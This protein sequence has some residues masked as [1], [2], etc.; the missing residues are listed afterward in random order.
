MHLSKEEK[1]KDLVAISARG[2]IKISRY[3]PKRFSFI[4]LKF[5]LCFFRVRLGFAMC[6]FLLFLNGRFNHSNSSS[7]HYL[8][9]ALSC[10]YFG[11]FCAIG[12]IF[13][14]KQNVE[15]IGSNVGVW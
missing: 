10:V 15:G 9:F 8:T 1:A 11:F 3:D 2:E 6:L 14:S 7:S 5:E 4:C 13:S 12:L